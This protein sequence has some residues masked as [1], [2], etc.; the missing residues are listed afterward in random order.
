M[1]LLKC[2]LTFRTYVMNVD[3]LR[4]RILERSAKPLS[5]TL[6][7]DTKAYKNHYKTLL[8]N[9]GNRYKHS[10]SDHTDTVYPP[11]SSSGEG[12]FW[13]EYLL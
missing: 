8:V 2:K 11:H 1:K 10:Y 3:T 6:T 7:D 4:H 9:I 12:L 5:I 13:N